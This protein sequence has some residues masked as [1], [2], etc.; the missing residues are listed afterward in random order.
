MPNSAG[1]T[2]DGFALHRLRT[3]MTDYAQTDVAEAAGITQ[4]ML[5]YILAGKKNASLKT[6]EAI[7]EALGMS[8]EVRTSV[9]FRKEK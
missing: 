9:I 2:L 5:S 8:V 4:A 7:A 6:L 3:M 1:I